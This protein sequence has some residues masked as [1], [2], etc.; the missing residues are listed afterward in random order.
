MIFKY[1]PTGHLICITREECVVYL[2]PTSHLSRNTE[3]VSSFRYTMQPTIPRLLWERHT[4]NGSVLYWR[5]ET[6]VCMLSLESG[7]IASGIYTLAQ[8]ERNTAWML[9]NV[10]LPPPLFLW[11]EAMVDDDPVNLQ[12]QLSTGNNV[13]LP[14]KYV[15]PNHRPQIYMMYHRMTFFSAA[16]AR[17]G[18]IQ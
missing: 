16:P 4:D 15:A 11:P 9:G 14:A 8:M 12:I 5:C 7:N 2:T 10:S 17:W 1:W 6:C 13:A 18:H 3:V